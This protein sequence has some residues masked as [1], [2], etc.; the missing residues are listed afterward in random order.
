MT[1][2]KIEIDVEFEIGETA[3]FANENNITMEEEVIEKVIT[4][5]WVKKDIGLDSI[6]VTYFFE[7]CESAYGNT[8]Q[9]HAY[10]TRELAQQSLDDG[11]AWGQGADEVTDGN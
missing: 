1:K 5:I 9:S 10:R 8:T 2:V 6:E 11:S 7:P 4:D 3:F